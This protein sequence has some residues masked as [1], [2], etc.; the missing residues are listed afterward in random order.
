[1]A[2]G[3]WQ[4]KRALVGGRHSVHK[5]GGGYR[6]LRGQVR[7]GESPELVQ[8]NRTKTLEHHRPRESKGIILYQRY[9]SRPASFSQTSSSCSLQPLACLAWHA[10]L[11]EDHGKTVVMKEPGAQTAS[12]L[13]IC[14]STWRT[15]TVPG[16]R[17]PHKVLTDSLP[18]LR[19]C[20]G[21]YAI[22]YMKESRLQICRVGQS[23]AFLR[24][25]ASAHPRKCW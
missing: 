14:R 11:Q 17:R 1:M 15:R 20:S 13:C 3:R 9:S 25:A 5:D 19:C 10:G 22:R 23:Q 4:T 18:L 24:C 8:P 21:N 6:L 16:S 2:D 12:H 7:H